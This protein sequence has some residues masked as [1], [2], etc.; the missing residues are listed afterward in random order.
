[1]QR[2][3][4]LSSVG[5][6]AASC[7]CDRERMSAKNTKKGTTNTEPV[8]SAVGSKFGVTVVVSSWTFF[9]RSG[10]LQLDF[11]F[12]SVSI[13]SWFMAEGE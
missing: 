1:M 5:V 2:A 9:I 7:R 10:S 6:F 12:L 3:W 13:T 4:P 11:L 8:L